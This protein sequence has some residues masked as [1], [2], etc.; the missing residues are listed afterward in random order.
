MSSPGRSRRAARHL[1]E[2]AEQREA[3]LL[4]GAERVVAGLLVFGIGRADHAIGPVEHRRP[5]LAGHAEQLG[6]H[7]ER[8]RPRQ[9]LDEV[10][11]LHAAVAHHRV[12]QVARDRLDVAAHALESARR[13]AMA[14]ELAHER[15]VGWIHVQQMTH[16]GGSGALGRRELGE[17]RQAR[18]VQEPLGLLRDP[19]DVGVLRD[20]PERIDDVAVVPVDRI[21]AAQARPRVVR[22]AVRRVRAVADDV[23]RVDSRRVSAVRH[24]PP[25]AQAHGDLLRGAQR[26]QAR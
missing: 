24:R 20:R 21:F 17:R 2:V 12:E 13:E 9:A 5:H 15:V 3:R 10:A 22:I 19:D 4:R 18:S 16:D 25:P 26:P 23:E 7:L 6:E 1:G 8:Q 11:L 14:R